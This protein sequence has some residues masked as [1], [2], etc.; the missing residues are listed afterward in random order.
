MRLRNLFIALVCHPLVC[1][2][3]EPLTLERLAEIVAMPHEDRLDET[4]L[5]VYPK[6]REYRLT[7]TS[8]L[9]DGQS[10]TG[11]AT[12]TEKWVGGRYIVSEAQPAG[13]D[14]KFA[15]VVEYD[16]DSK[17][18]RKYIV[19][20][21]KLSGFQE[22]T[23]VA[24]SRSVAWIDLSSSKF[25]AGIDCLTTET[26]TDTSTTWSSTFYQKGQFQRSE[27]GVAKVTK[28]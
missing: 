25:D 4:A 18:Y 21:G 2:A 13:P 14:T 9:S 5:K 20:A 27:T 11:K 19:M 8:T 7:I 16:L 1:T 3:A 17:R 22:G 28:P 15:M 26:H 6:A 12:A 10:G 24:D 23:R